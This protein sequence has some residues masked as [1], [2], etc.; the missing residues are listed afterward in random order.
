MV[1]NCNR[2]SR[3]GGRGGKQQIL[4]TTSGPTAVVRAR[5]YLIH[6]PLVNFTSETLPNKIWGKL[7]WDGM[8]LMTE[9]SSFVR[10]ERWTLADT[11]STPSRSSQ[12]ACA[13]LCTHPPASSCFAANSLNPRPPEIDLRQCSCLICSTAS[14]LGSDLECLKLEHSPNHREPH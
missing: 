12:M 5:A 4:V 3:K 7:W 6:I 1:A 9:P 11:V 2:V 14:A 10:C 8:D 13:V